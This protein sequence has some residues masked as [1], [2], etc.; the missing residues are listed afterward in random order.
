MI[1]GRGG[2]K[3]NND[4]KFTEKLST[5]KNRR[6]KNFIAII[7]VDKNNGIKIGFR[8]ETI[9]G[10]FFKNKKKIKRKKQ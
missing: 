5:T 2:R 7:E 8:R 4:T 9:M 10:F 1:K 6:L 3:Q